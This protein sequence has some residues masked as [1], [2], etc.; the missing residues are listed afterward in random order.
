MES[1]LNRAGVTRK[2]GALAQAAHA[3]AARVSTA[4]WDSPGPRRVRGVHPRLSEETMRT[5]SNVEP[6]AIEHLSP[7]S[8][9]RDKFFRELAA[10][11]LPRGNGHLAPVTEDELA[12][13]PEP[14]QRYMRFMAVVGRPRNWSFCARWDGRF[15]M[16]PDKPWMPCEAWQYNTSLEIARIFHMRVRIGGVVPT[17]VRDLYVDGGGHMVGKLF[18]KLA[19]VDDASE[20]VTIGELVTYVN[21]ALM[22]APSMLLRPSTLWTPIDESSF[23]VTTTDHGTT[24]TGRVLVEADGAMKDFST[25][26]RFGQ[27]PANP[28]AGMVR[29]R[30][31]TPID[32]WTIVN[33]RPRPT[34]G[35]AIWH[36]ATGDF[37]YAETTTDK[38]DLAFDVPPGSCAS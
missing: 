12:A 17:Y 33:G 6:S 15:R 35:R 14:A 22:F 13:L 19:I 32:G 36:F 4:W 26:D 34:E 23:D 8:R 16:G 27:E 9:M 20:K 18:D 38:M 28:K 5:S 31:T 21:D 37:C 11:G 25:T 24:V 30:W 29:T 2:T 10:L 1:Y 3:L 7:S